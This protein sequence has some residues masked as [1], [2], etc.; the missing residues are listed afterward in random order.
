MQP[1]SRYTNAASA[2]P[3]DSAHHT[4]SQDGSPLRGDAAFG[5][6]QRGSRQPDWCGTFVVEEQKASRQRRIRDP[7][8]FLAR[9]RKRDGSPASRPAR[10]VIFF[11]TSPE[12]TPALPR[13]S[14]R[15]RYLRQAE[16]H[17]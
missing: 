9:R 14:A 5:H 3:A 12:N 15:W 16:D 10:I 8:A 6:L 7:A 17:Q 13:S 4:T 2:R 11:S 1:R